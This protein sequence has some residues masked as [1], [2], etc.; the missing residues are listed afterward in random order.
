MLISIRYTKNAGNAAIYVRLRNAA[1]QFWDFTSLE[2]DMA[3][4]SVCRVFFTERPDA[5]TAESLYLADVTIP[6]GGPWVSEAVRIDTGA[7][8]GNDTTAIDANISA[9]PTTPLL[10]AD[11]TAPAT[12]AEIAAA[13][14]SALSR[15]LTTSAGATPAE[16][17]TAVWAE[18]TRTLT[19][20]G[21][22]VPATV[23]D[24]TGYAL[25]TAYDPAKTAATQASVDLVAGGVADT[26]SGVN[27]LLSG[28]STL[29]D[30]GQGK[31]EIV[32]NQMIFYDRAGD[33]LQR[34]NLQDLSG[35]PTMGDVFKRVPV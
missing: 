17:A 7:V 15:T 22:T 2:W 27:L 29:L 31:W 16:I 11:Y 28:V 4:T 33:E 34:F 8:I 1:G 32:A 26:Q 23:S 19:A 20:F 9:I 10:A 35:N 24:K 13:V 12:T 25:T 3:E 21:F 30:I 5:D 6:A 14:W 18:T